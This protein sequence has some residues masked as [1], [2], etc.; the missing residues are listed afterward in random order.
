M[1]AKTAA[2]V[3]AIC[4]K[5]GDVWHVVVAKVG[6]R[7]AKVQCKECGAYHRYRPPK[8]GK[9]ASSKKASKPRKR[10]SKSTAK[11]SSKK[12]PAT[13]PEGPEIEPDMSKP[14]RAYAHGQAYEPAERVEHPKF[15]IGV[16][17]TAGDGKMTVFFPAGRRVLVQSKPTRKLKRPAPFRHDTNE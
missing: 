4:S 6:D 1:S 16:V 12:T 2:D 15:G 5:C 8:S 10:S 13:V 3:E 9:K 7:I 11:L 14:V 17:E